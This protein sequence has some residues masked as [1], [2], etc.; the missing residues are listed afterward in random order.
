[1][2]GGLDVVGEGDR[3]PQCKV[4]GE[5]GYTGRGSKG[6][7]RARGKTRNGTHDGWARQHMVRVE[8]TAAKCTRTKVKTAREL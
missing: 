2:R 8:G 3:I 6:E 7:R 5:R 4:E 1:M